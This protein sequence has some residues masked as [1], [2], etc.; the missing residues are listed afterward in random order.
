MR[1][2]SRVIIEHIYPQIEAGLHPIKSVVQEIIPVT[3]H[4]LAD[5]HDVIAA[6]LCYKHEKSK[7]WDTARMESTG[8][9]EWKS[10][11]ITK[12]QGFFSNFPLDMN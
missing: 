4:I 1:N 9:D 6:N 3:A 8:N 5:G 10:S 12:K 7:K 2:Q 11:F